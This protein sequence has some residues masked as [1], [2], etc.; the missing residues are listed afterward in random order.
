VA[1][2]FCPE[3]GCAL[4]VRNIISKFELTAK[5]FFMKSILLIVALYSFFVY[6]QTWN[7]SG[8]W[9]SVG[10]NDK[11]DSPA[12][13]SACGVGPAEFVRIYKNNPDYMLAGSLSG[14][15][16][17]SEDGGENW[18]NSGSDAWDYSGCG[19]ADFYPEN[20]DIWFAYSNNADNNG[21]PGKMGVRGGILRTKDAGIT[22]EMIAG[23]NELG[24]SKIAVYGFRFLPS[25]PNVLFVLSEAGLF[26]TKDCLAE[27]VAW[28]KYEGLNGSIY[29]M[30]F[31]NDQA[32][33]SSLKQN[34]WSVYRFDFASQKQE[35]IPQIESIS[36]D[37]RS[38]TFEPLNEKLVVLIDY[39]KLDDEIWEYHPADTSFIQLKSGVQVNFGSGHTFA[40][41]PHNQSEIIIGNSISMKRYSYPSMKENKLGSGYHVDV[42]FVAY[43]PTDTNKIFIA[44]HGG[45]YVSENK[46]SKWISKSNGLGIAEVMGLD[47][48]ETDPNQL[49]IGCF[50][51]GSSVYA[52]YNKNGNYFWRTVNGGDALTPLINY[53]NAAE[54]YTSTQFA[55]GGLY[56]SSDTSN[57]VM[58]IHSANGLTTPGWE[59]TAVLH[60]ENP[61]WLF[62]NFQSAN[63]PDVRMDVARSNDIT[64]QKN[65]E[66]ISD[67]SKYGM[68]S[69][70]VYGL[71]NNKF[72]PDHLYAY[73][74]H[75]EKNEEGKNIT[76][77]RLFK[78]EIAGDSAAKIIDSW[79]EL[80]VPVSAWIGDVEGDPANP[81][82]IFISYAS[83]GDDSE[84]KMI[85][86]VKYNKKTK[87]VKQIIDL[88]R[89]IPNSV[90]GRF[91]MVCLNENGT[92]LFIATR[93]GVYYGNK[94]TLKGKGDWIKV[95]F[96]LPHCKVY[97]LHYH[98]QAKI[99][100]VGMFGR[101]VW[102]YRF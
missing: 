29:D 64:K 31:V 44:C 54:V 23:G 1:V 88:T 90:G 2:F 85:Y 87:G 47:V 12:N 4:K 25:N 46:G 32:F 27:K 89:N 65:V 53:K 37:K 15:L 28:I 74:L 14:G 75:F 56:H 49:V 94:K 100:T 38:I 76:K 67:F 69:Y 66:T 58:N 93:T 26:Y 18:L 82:R 80:E 71:F 16:F 61:D 9:E 3:F 40:V 55:G 51:D 35:T 92:E 8:A 52:D 24:T 57:S 79:Y 70:K 48:S 60:P 34:K 10:P 83:A 62:F 6:S 41:N 99:L 33:V 50:H 20:K 11:P 77:H 21:K 63:T 36:D 17:V 72:F 13:I 42:E 91:N 95:G 30:D 81:D 45:I 5:S 68:S 97:G 43:H 39:T 102:R 19:W 7:Y 101:G 22:W 73:V 78:T 96:G 86:A 84:N 59:L 98:V